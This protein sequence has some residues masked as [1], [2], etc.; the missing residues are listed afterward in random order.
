[1]QLGHTG[2]ETPV[3]P[4][5]HVTTDQA[6]FVAGQDSKPQLEFDWPVPTS[7]ALLSWCS[8]RQHM[9]QLMRLHTENWV[10]VYVSDYI[11]TWTTT[12]KK[13]QKHLDKSGLG[14]CT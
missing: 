10:N 9:Q 1:M 8:V 4:R 11:L 14:L 3:A 2:C 6:G 13:C 5:R 7:A 12:T